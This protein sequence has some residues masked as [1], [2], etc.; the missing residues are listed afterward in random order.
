MQSKEQIIEQLKAAFS[1]RK[2]PDNQHL[3]VTDALD[4]EREPLEALLI[5]KE[6]WDLTPD[7]IRDVVSSNLWMFT[8]VA[9]HYYLP[10]FLAAMLKD[11]GNMGLFSDEMLDSL[12]RPRVGDADR[13]LERFEGKSE[14]QF[15]AQ[16]GGI[17]HEWYSSGWPDTLFL[18][19]YGTLSEPE[20]QAVLA[21]LTWLQTYAKN[22]YDEDEIKEVIERHWNV[23]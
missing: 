17:F 9:F 19:R 6:P 11:K 4:P 12:M 23:S 10:A 7:D 18:H 22:E 5:Q 15:I 8:P 13:K 1:Q 21:V 20:K 3:L 16:L 14:S 2:K